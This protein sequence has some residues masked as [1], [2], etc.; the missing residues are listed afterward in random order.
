[1]MASLEPDRATLWQTRREAPSSS[2]D[3]LDRYVARFPPSPFSPEHWA[4]GIDVMK[5][6]SAYIH[7]RTYSFGI[8]KLEKT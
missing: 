5:M 8:Y 1:M 7:I 4:R 2:N 3:P 6:I